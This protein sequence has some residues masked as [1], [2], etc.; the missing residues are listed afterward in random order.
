MLYM[1]DAYAR[2]FN[3][4]VKRVEGNN[5]ILDKTYFYA[6]SG[7]QPND[8]GKLIANEEYDVVNVIKD[9]NEI[10]HEVNKNGLKKDDKVKGTINW[11]R[12]YKLMRMH[13]AAHVLSG[14]F[15]KETNAK[16]T[17]GQLDLDKSRFDFSLE[18]FDR[19][20][21]NEYFEK[22]NELVKKD[23][24]VKTYYISK[25]EAMNMPEIFKLAKAL[26][27]MD[28]FRIVE[29]NGFD[30][31]ADGGTHVKSLMEIGKIIFLKAEN[32]GKDNRRVYYTLE[33]IT[34]V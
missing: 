18:N 26:P 9:N 30:K 11:E 27:D 8:T 29:I 6:A 16:I 28:R 1:E 21:I 32:K 20:K 19:D 7:G 12:R 15:Y 22:A 25:K 34:K 2:E 4:V 14:I 3:A 17:G 23:L 5:I 10:V 31:Q 33:K 13:T 24:K